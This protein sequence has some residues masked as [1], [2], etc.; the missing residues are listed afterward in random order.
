MI[1]LQLVVEGDT[2]EGFVNQVLSPYLAR[3][4]IYA[5]CH[6]VTTSRKRYRV[7][8]GGG[9]TYARWKKD[10]QLWLNDDRNREARFTTM[11]DLYGLPNDFPEFQ[12]AKERS[13]PYQRVRFLEETFGKDIGSPRFVPYI[14]LHEFEAL[15]LSDPSQFLHEFPGRVRPVEN[16]SS[17]AETKSTP[18]LIDDG[19]QTAPSKRI[20]REIPEYEGRKPSA[21]PL[22]AGH[23][24]IDRIRA[25][26]PHFN[27]WLEK[28]E[29]LAG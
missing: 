1:R 25:R 17:L 12:K 2:E 11:V 9:E 14:Q 13:D 29:A 5:V 7:Y 6:R 22:I 27:E 16:L 28:I 15:L 3:R 21:G 19:E 8:R 18:E 24:G 20:A 23:I 10:L 4:E 26:C